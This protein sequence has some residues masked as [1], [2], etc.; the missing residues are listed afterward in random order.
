MDPLT[1]FAIVGV[2][3]TIYATKCTIECLVLG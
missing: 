2:G 3:F 1:F